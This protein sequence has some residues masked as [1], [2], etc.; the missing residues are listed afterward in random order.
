M[1]DQRDPLREP[2]N[3]CGDEPQVRHSFEVSKEKR[4]G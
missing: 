3:I 2:R 4:N 1:M